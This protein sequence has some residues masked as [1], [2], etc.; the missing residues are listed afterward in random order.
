MRGKK[1][2]I[3]EITYN[4]FLL[5][6]KSKQEEIK[7]RGTST[8][9]VEREELRDLGLPSGVPRDVW[10][11]G[12]FSEYGYHVADPIRILRVLIQHVQ[13]ARVEPGV[14][15]TCTGV[16]SQ[17][18]FVPENVEEIA[19]IGR[20][21]ERIHLQIWI[22]NQRFGFGRKSLAGDS[23]GSGISEFGSAESVI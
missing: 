4:F 11:D 9:S 17:H 22:R 13:K 3:S 6:K 15:H 7:R 12:P 2:T 1:T 16:V 18:P 19:R 23:Q 21:W 5:L 10:G 8:G 20:R 14:E